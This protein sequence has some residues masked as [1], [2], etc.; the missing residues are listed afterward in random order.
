MQPHF[1]LKVQDQ[2]DSWVKEILIQKRTENQ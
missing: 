2:I 1:F